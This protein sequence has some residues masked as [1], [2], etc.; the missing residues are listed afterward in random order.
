MK[1]LAVALVLFAAS[2]SK[3][4]LKV[5]YW[6]HGRTA[7]GTVWT[8][9]CA[10]AGGTHPFPGRSCL[11]LRAHAD[12]LRPATKPC[13]LLERAGSPEAAIAGTYAG[14]KVDRSYRVGCPG[15]NNLKLVLTG[16]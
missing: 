10:P 8:L 15:W 5:T 9:R 4:S 11:Q 13:T 16:S 6:P 12:D 1:L 3:A 14:R 7:A 2:G